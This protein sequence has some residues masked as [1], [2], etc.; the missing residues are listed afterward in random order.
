[1]TRSFFVR[2]R[3]GGRGGGRGSRKVSKHPYSREEAK[4]QANPHRRSARLYRISGNIVTERSKFIE[5]T[6]SNRSRQVASVPLCRL[7]ARSKAGR[8]P[9][10]GMD[11]TVFKK[12]SFNNPA[13]S[14]VDGGVYRWRA[15]ITARS[16]S[17]TDCLFDFH[18]RAIFSHR[19]LRP[20]LLSACTMRVRFMVDTRVQGIT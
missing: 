20:R 12:C 1:M 11:R 15:E 4:F 9:A 8:S 5:L 13:Q 10:R 14:A 18:V 6:S 19:F 17:E 2:R 7:F 3:E 16:R